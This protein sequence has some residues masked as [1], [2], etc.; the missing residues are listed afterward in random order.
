VLTGHVAG[1]TKTIRAGSGGVM[2]PN[3]SPLLITKQFG[4]LEALYP[5]RIDLGLAR[6]RFANKKLALQKLA[7]LPHI[8]DGGTL[9]AGLQF[10]S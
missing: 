5:G 9:F 1:A 7:L 3:H 4:T 8:K 6:W 2:L 10:T